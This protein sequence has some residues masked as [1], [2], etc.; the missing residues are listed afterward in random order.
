MSKAT[1]FSWRGLKFTW[2]AAPARQNFSSSKY[3]GGQHYF[4]HAREVGGKWQAWVDGHP[5]GFLRESRADALDAALVA[6]IHQM[7]LALPEL[8][9]FAEGT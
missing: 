2:D 4:F 7:Q 8:Q 9:K 3:F 6:L 1:T 5:S